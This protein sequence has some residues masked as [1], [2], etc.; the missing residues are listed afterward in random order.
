MNEEEADA[1]YEEEKERIF[2]KYTMLFEQKGR[3][4]AEKKFHEEMDKL[5]KDYNKKYD[6]LAA[7]KKILEKIKPIEQANKKVEGFLKGIKEAYK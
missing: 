2:Q 1:W 6:E 3:E 5:M 4:I 7:K